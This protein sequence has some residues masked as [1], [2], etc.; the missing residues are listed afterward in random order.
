MYCSDDEFSPFLDI[1]VWLEACCCIISML[2]V[3]IALLLFIYLF[4]FKFLLQ[5]YM[6]MSE[7][8]SLIS[9]SALL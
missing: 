4:I 3:P 1:F 2:S 8:K 9:D 6:I 5:N 7:F